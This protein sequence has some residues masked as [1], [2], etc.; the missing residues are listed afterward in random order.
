VSLTTIGV[1]TVGVL[2]GA[3]G[4]SAGSATCVRTVDAAA[5]G[6]GAEAALRDALADA[7]D[8][9]DLDDCTD[10]SVELSG[11][12]TLT[13]ELVWDVAVPLRIVGPVG[14]TARIQAAADA[15]HRLLTVDT[16]PD[17]VLVTLERLVLSGGDVAF[18][19][20]FDDQGGA[21]LADGLHLIDMELIGNAAVAG[22]AVSTIDLRAERTSFVGNEAEFGVGEGGAVRATGEVVLTNVT[23]SGNVAKQGGA[24]FLNLSAG[25]SLTATFVTFL[26]N[27]ASDAQSGADLHLVAAVGGTPAV[28]LRGVLFGGPAAASDAGV[29]GGPYDLA[30]SGSGLVWTASFATDTS[31]GAPVA[32]PQPA[33]ETVPWLPGTTAL[34][35]PGSGAPSVGA[36]PCGAGWPT[37]DQRGLERPQGEAC[38]AGAVE[39]TAGTLELPPEQLEEQPDEEQPAQGVELDPQGR[40]EQGGADTPPVPR[41]IPAG[42]GA[43]RDGCA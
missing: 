32:T 29:C 35:V 23:F 33:F 2:W 40:S 38:D 43:C 31:C 24:V 10:W 7:A 1:L 42:G 26:D 28:T 19:P 39:R 21:V 16:F 25:G 4:P 34:P 15:D 27:A 14:T 30:A 41:S 6:A 3:A 18:G 37:S 22:G 12:V 5:A 17:R 36:V 9:V 13:S 11:T 8:G 20:S